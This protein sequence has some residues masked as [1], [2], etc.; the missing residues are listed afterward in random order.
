MMITICPYCE[1]V[2]NHQT[3]VGELSGRPENGD[4]SVCAGC[5][6]IAIFDSTAPTNVRKP[7]EGEEV[8]IASSDEVKQARATIAARTIQ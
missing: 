5:G 4:A 7:T 8:A 2:S 6:E 3:P 1:N